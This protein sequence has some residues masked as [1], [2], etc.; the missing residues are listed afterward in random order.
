M[1]L[2]SMNYWGSTVA[3]RAVGVFTSINRATGKELSQAVVVAKVAGMKCLS[4]GT[5]CRH[6]PN[7]KAQD[8]WQE[9]G[10]NVGTEFA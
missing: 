2:G 5:N 3:A 4:V 6:M 1:I 10:P 7:G 9:L 8:Q